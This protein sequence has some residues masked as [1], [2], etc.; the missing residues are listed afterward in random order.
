[1]GPDWVQNEEQLD[2]D[3][4]ERKDTTHDNSG[5]WF[6]VKDLLR[7]FSLDRVGADRMLDRSIF[8]AIESS[9]E[10]KWDGNTKPQKENDDEGSEWNS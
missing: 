4:A 5:N 2:E 7:D 8:V 3:A 10:G 1:M 9:Q 6:C